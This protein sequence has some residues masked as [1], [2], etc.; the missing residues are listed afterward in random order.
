MTWTIQD[1]FKLE[2]SRFEFLCVRKLS[3]TLFFDAVIK[4]NVNI[5][6]IDSSTQVKYQLYSY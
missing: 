1:F 2:I 6:Q 4:K 3:R 5:D